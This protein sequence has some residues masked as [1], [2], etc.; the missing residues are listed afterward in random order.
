[1]VRFRGCTRCVHVHPGLHSR[2]RRGKGEL[3]FL[4]KVLSHKQM[5]PGRAAFP[6]L[7][8]DLGFSTETL[9]NLTLACQPYGTGQPPMECRAAA[10]IGLV[11]PDN[12]ASPLSMCTQALVGDA[13]KRQARMSEAGWAWGVCILTSPC[14]YKGSR[15]PFLFPGGSSLSATCCPGPPGWLGVGWLEHSNLPVGAEWPTLCWVKPREG[16]A[17]C[18][19]SWSYRPSGEKP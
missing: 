10:T 17:E 4:G 5:N 2:S 15:E 16:Q 13:V 18:P 1:M 8:T 9:L 12:S 3:Q 14:W 11:V 6:P 19:S 7:D